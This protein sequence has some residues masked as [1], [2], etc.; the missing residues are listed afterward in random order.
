[1]YNPVIP[2]LIV[3]T[4]IQAIIRAMHFLKHTKKL[5]QLFINLGK[6]YDFYNNIFIF[7]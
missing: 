1:M 3:S 4:Y 7:F 6:K 2:K 5:I